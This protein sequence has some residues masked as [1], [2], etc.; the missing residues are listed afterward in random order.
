MP[1]CPS[2][3]ELTDL[4]Y[5]LLA[6]ARE[7]ELRTHLE[8]CPACGA[9]AAELAAVISGAGAQA[10]DADAP[11]G[12]REPGARLGRYTLLERLGAGAMGEVFAAHDPEGGGRQVALKLLRTEA[13]T[14]EAVEQGR[15]RL[16]R[17]ARIVARLAH[18]HIVPVLDM[19]QAGQDV[20]LAMER[21]RGHTLTHWLVHAQERTW[22]EV[23]AAFLQ[24]GRGLAGAHAAGV[25]HRDFKPDNVLVG[26]DGRVRVT[27]FGL[28]KPT[29]GH[30]LLVGAAADGG[31][32][33]LT[34]LGVVLGTRAYMAPEQARGE[35]ATPLSDQYSFCV[36]LH[37][38]LTGKR[39]GANAP[40]GPP[41]RLR[42]PRAVPRWLLQAVA[43][44][45]RHRPAE[46]YPSMD[47]LLATL[48]GSARARRR[49]A[50]GVGA[51][52]LVAAAL[53][54]AAFAAVLVTAAPPQREGGGAAGDSRQVS[55]AGDPARGTAR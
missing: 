38:A 27:D 49:R 16:L 2:E 15:Q 9:L 50:W 44:G 10:A 43:R 34:P 20:Y 31:S 25:V 32:A 26:E 14:P 51:A 6:T 21:V 7:R 53:V 55:R 41:L 46:R 30:V 37:E 33:D 29:G 48:D 24:A 36:A 13:L 54:A 28:A 45:L 8:G 17:E 12:D 40:L 3:T 23:L 22:Q 52:A 4:L 42:A 35:V 47:A 5:G 1:S 18:P 19:G 39:P 11:G